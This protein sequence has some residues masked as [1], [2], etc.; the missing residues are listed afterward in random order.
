MSLEDV[1]PKIEESWKKVLMPFFQ[2]DS[3]VSLKKFLVE[4]KKIATVYPPSFFIF[5]AFNQ[6]PFSKVKVVILGQD[7][8]HG[9]GQAN[10]LSFSVTEGQRQPPS[11]KNIF[12]ELETD[13]NL[14]SP[15]SGD[16][17]SWAKQGVLLLNATLTVEKSKPGS[18]QQQGW[19]TFTD[20]V[21]EQ[22]SQSKENLVFLLWGKFAQSKEILIDSKKHLILQ[23]THPSPFS[24][25]RGFLGCRHFSKTNVYL[26]QN[27]IASIDWR[28]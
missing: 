1:K 13:L 15:S 24:A 2:K 21:I 25:H 11:L 4:R 20:N 5:S 9:E 16:L 23:S 17:S 12:K 14:S 18:H 26:E 6:T 22:L 3:F 7:P 28:L 8:Y 19:E 27:K 10:G